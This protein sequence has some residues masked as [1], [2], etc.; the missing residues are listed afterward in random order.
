MIALEQWPE[1]GILNN[2]GAWL[3]GT[4]KHHAI[5][6]IRRNVRLQEREA[7]LAREIEADLERD[8]TIGPDEVADGVL[9]L[10]FTVCHPVLPIEGRVAL[11]LRVVGGLTTERIARAFLVPVATMGKRIVRAKHSLALARVPF[12]FPGT[13]ELALRLASVLEVV[14]L[15]FNE[16]YTATA[17]AVRTAWDCALCG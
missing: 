11:T 10:M 15:I 6:E 3:M 12:E 8:P 9:R 7:Q 14:Y 2:P 13:S 16:G 1:S 17:L 5:D 4:A